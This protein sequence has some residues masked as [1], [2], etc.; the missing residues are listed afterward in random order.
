MWDDSDDDLRDD[1]IPD[2]ADD[3]DDDGTAP[4]PHCGA[5]IFE[6]SERCPYCENYL[7]R[8]DRP[9]DKPLWIVAGAVACLG[10]VMSWTFGRSWLV[11]GGV[12]A[13]A[14]VLFG[15]RPR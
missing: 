11:L 4:C 9:W 1:E 6:D 12:L 7:S 2:E 3:D 14:I 10:A 5:P 8:E 15:K 13:V